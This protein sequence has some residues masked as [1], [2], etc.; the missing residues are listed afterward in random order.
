MDGLE[1]TR[2]I[3]QQAGRQQ[4]RIVMLTASAFE[5]ERQQALA[6]GADDFLRKPIEADKLFVV[7]EQQLKLNFVRR[8]V[9]HAGS[10]APPAAQLLPSELACMP[11]QQRAA[12]LLAVRELDSSKAGAI[13]QQLGPTCAALA[14][15]LQAMLDHHQY[16][17][18][19]QLL[20][21]APLDGAAE[22]LAP[23]VPVDR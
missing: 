7:L 9:L 6:A 3:R 22:L 4:P 11:E 20:Q 1:L 5:E 2:W 10:A 23:V 18:L 8:E 17:Q 15:R 13:L 14:P 16:R 12:L 21:P 19:W